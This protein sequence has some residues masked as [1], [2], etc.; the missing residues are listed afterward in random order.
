[1][2]CDRAARP[3][4]TGSAQ[5]HITKVS[6]IARIEKPL[7]GTVR[8]LLVT[9]PD[10]FM[11]PPLTPEPL[12]PPPLSVP[13]PLGRLRKYLNI[14]RVSLIERLAYRGDF[15]LG[16]VL[17]FFPVMTTILLWQAVYAGARA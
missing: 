11:D 14:Y 17:R 3:P 9:H 4:H 7:L 13:G 5:P 1:M 10:R 6:T 12:T 8:G 15:L 2:R 16:T